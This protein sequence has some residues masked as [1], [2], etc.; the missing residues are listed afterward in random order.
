MFRRYQVENG[1]DFFIFKSRILHNSHPYEECVNR[2]L[3]IR[4]WHDAQLIAIISRY[5]LGFDIQSTHPA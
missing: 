2:I 5:E 3:P 4:L 1:K